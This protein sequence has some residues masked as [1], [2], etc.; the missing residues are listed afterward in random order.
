MGKENA[1]V[2]LGF[3]VK[4]G[5]ENRIFIQFKNLIYYYIIIFIHILNP[6]FLNGGLYVAKLLLGIVL[7]KELTSIN[8][9]PPFC[10]ASYLPG[11]ISILYN[12]I[13]TT[14]LCSLGINLSSKP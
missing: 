4:K 12:T 1:V 6:S 3:V 8:V 7:H 9:L 11:L 13:N 10:R 2:N 5:T 14:L